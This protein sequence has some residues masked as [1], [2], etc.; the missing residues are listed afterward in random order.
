LIKSA[1]H[2]ELCNR[3]GCVRVESDTGQD[4]KQDKD[5]FHS[6]DRANFAISDRRYGD[7]SQGQGAHEAA[8]LKDPIAD[9]SRNLG[10]ECQDDRYSEMVRAVYRGS[11]M[12]AC[13]DS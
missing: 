3:S 1:F 6:I 2:H 4:D 5:M 11:N 8:T 10:Q 7:H 13:R 9:H 12:P